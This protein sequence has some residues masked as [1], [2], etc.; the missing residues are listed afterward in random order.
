[1]RKILL[2]GLAICALASSASAQTRKKSPP[3]PASISAAERDTLT[4]TCAQ[5]QALVRSKEGIV[6]RTGPNHFDLYVHD[7]EACGSSDD[8]SPAFVRTKDQ[9][10][11]HIGYTCEDLSAD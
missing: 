1:M 8:L 11:C 10:S 2:T 7:A 5:S 9:R 3:K 6:L 4:M